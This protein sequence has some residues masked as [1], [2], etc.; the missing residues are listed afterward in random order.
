MS[1]SQ[2]ILTPLPYQISDLFALTHIGKVLDYRAA[3]HARPLFAFPAQ[4]VQLSLEILD[5]LVEAGG[6]KILNGSLHVVD[7]PLSCLVF[8]TGLT[9]RKSDSVWACVGAPGVRG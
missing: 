2:I 5:R 1:V 9:D 3:V 8:A 7:S 6:V 4:L